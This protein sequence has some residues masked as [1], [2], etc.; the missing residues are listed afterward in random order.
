MVLLLA[1]I[2]LLSNLT[3][4]LSE[5]RQDCEHECLDFSP[6]VGSVLYYTVKE[7]SCVGYNDHIIGTVVVKQDS[8]GQQW[9]SLVSILCEI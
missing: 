7:S 1:C 3:V 6:S 4:V 5:F 9:C 8:C 2:W